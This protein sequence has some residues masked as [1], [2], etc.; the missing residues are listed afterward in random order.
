MKAWRIAA[1]ISCCLILASGCSMCQHPY[2]YCG[3]VWSEGDCRNCNPDYRAGS[4]LNRQGPGVM[5]VE[6]TAR[7]AQPVGRVA[8]HAYG[9]APAAARVKR[10]EQVTARRSEGSDA[11]VTAH[12]SEG[13][14]A[15]VRATAVAP[16]RRTPMRLPAES[17]PAQAQPKRTVMPEAPLPRIICHRTLS[18]LPQ[19][20]RRAHTR[21]LS[22]TDRRLDELPKNR[23]PV[24][25]ERKAPQQDSGETQRRFRRLA[26]RGA[27]IRTPWKP[28]AGCPK[29][30]ADRHATAAARSSR[31]RP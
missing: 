30:S 25:L 28:Q 1:G 8:D 9:A 3:P 29:S 14:D 17:Q 6:D 15:R 5:T 31:R 21:I 7:N 12:R 27:P 24:A 13:S 18:P 22:V 4:I 20:P 10:P 19:G 26:A 2:D 23:K 11:H 16:Q